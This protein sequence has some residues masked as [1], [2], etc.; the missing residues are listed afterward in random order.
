MEYW[1]PTPSCSRRQRRQRLPGQRA[2]DRL[3][4]RPG[5]RCGGL[6][7]EDHQHSDGSSAVCAE[8]VILSPFDYGGTLPPRGPRPT[9]TAARSCRTRSFDLTGPILGP[10]D[11]VS[12]VAATFVA[13]LAVYAAAYAVLLL[14]RSGLERRE[15]AAKR[16]QA[17]GS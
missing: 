9:V 4:R 12:S 2:D 10:L 14:V 11:A 6:R 5:A 1:R 8:R 16:R 13:M 7:V 15:A 17:S 3:S